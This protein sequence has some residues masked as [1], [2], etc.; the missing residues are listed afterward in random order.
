MAKSKRF[1]ARK[2]P[3][4]KVKPGKPLFI[5][6]DNVNAARQA[7]YEF[8]RR[9]GKVWRIAIIPDEGIVVTERKNIAE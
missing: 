5:E 1:Y 3:W 7:G 6:T 2:Y 4:N 8:A 9:Y